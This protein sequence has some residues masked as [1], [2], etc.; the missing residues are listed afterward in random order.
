MNKNKRKHEE[1]AAKIS[2][3]IGQLLNDPDSD[4]H[5]S[6]EDLQEGDNM[7]EFVH[8]LA[9]VAPCFIVINLT[10]QANNWLTFNHQANHLIVQTLIELNSENND[11]V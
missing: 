4:F 11:E 7:T 3:A 5:I 2:A 6:R 8:A 1:Y 10:N 9:T